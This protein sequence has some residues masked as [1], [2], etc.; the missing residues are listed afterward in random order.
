[1]ARWL[2][3]T[4]ATFN[5]AAARASDKASTG[6]FAAAPWAAM[7]AIEESCHRRGHALIGAHDPHR[8]SARVQ[9]CKREGYNS[10]RPPAHPIAV[11][12][13]EIYPDDCQPSPGRNRG[14]L[15]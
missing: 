6:I 5:N 2:S 7:A 9:R 8:T 11:S 10:V 4:E 13:V 14:S 15:T 3:S 1:M 12:M